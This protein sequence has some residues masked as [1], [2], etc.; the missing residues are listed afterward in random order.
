MIANRHRLWRVAIDAVLIA[1]AW[2]LAFKIR[3]L[4][5]RIPPFYREYLDVET[6]AIV[7]GVK[8]VVF[9]L[10]GFYHRWWR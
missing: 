4:D 10:F 2:Y 3:F 8:L 1:L 5:L 9:T 6:I 7:V